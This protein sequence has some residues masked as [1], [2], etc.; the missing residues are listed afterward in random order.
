MK[1]VQRI[2]ANINIRARRIALRH[3]LQTNQKFSNGFISDGGCWNR[4]STM[5]QNI[6]IVSILFSWALLLNE[7]KTAKQNILKTKITINI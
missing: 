4:F 5:S 3:P 2:R 7:D 1:T 6:S